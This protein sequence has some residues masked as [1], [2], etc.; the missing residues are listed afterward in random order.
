[1]DF[2]AVGVP[3]AFG[4]CGRITGDCGRGP[5]GCGRSTGFPQ[6]GVFE[7]VGGSMIL[8]LLGSGMGADLGARGRS[9]P[10]CFARARV[11]AKRLCGRGFAA[12]FAVGFREIRAFVGGWAGPVGCCVGFGEAGA[13]FWGA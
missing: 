8:N 7:P 10:P 6:E 13:D 5:V 4:G 9:G 12:S 2:A 3:T 1:V 11:E